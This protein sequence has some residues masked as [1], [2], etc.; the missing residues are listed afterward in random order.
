MQ[1]TPYSCQILIKLEFSQHIFENSSNIKFYGNSS[2]GSRV[3]PS[4]QAGGK[5]D[6]HDK[7]LVA[8]RNFANAPKQRQFN[9]NN[10]NNNN[11]NIITFIVGL[12]F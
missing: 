11:N 5:T 6:G 3:V 2:S 12:L 10:N 1:S 8:F 4:G 7:L 9:N